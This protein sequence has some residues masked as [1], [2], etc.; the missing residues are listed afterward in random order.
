MWHTADLISTADVRR[1]VEDGT[2]CPT[3][4]QKNAQPHRLGL[5]RLYRS[6]CN[7]SPHVC[8]MVFNYMHPFIRGIIVSAPSWSALCLP[9][10]WHLSE[11]LISVVLTTS[12]YGAI[13]LDFKWLHHLGWV[14]RYLTLDSHCGIVQFPNGVIPISGPNQQIPNLEYFSKDQCVWW[15]FLTLLWFL[16]QNESLIFS[17]VPC[18]FW[19][20]IKMVRFHPLSLFQRWYF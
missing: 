9:K 19:N 7:V 8:L 1:L 4:L 13:S 2:V 5:W 17:L 6:V 20:F 14:G 18:H 16:H 12:F 10:I 15:I 3:A 11:K